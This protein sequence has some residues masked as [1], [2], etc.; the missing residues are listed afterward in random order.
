MKYEP[1]SLSYQSPASP[2]IVL[3]IQGLGHVPSFKNNKRAVIQ[4]R[5]GRSGKQFAKICTEPETKEWM[6]RATKAI[7]S[8]LLSCLQ[9]VEG[10]TS[11]ELWRQSLTASLPLDDCWEAIPEQHVFAKLVKKGEEGCMITIERISPQSHL[12]ASI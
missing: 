9:T 12:P 6:E 7:A 3:R 4:Y 5:K 11:A 2:P 10:E 8:Q 1:D